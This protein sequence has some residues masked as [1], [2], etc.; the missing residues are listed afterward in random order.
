MGTPAHAPT[1]RP[2]PTDLFLAA[3]GFPVG[4]LL[5]AVPPACRRG[6]DTAPPLRP[7]GDDA[8]LDFPEWRPRRPAARLVP[9]LSVLD[10][11]PPGFRFELSA[12]TSGAWSPWVGAASVGDV[13]FA[14]LPASA[15]ALTSEIDEFVA[16]VPADAVRLRARLPAAGAAVLA[17]AP[18]LVALSAWDGTVEASGPRATSAVGLAVPPRSQMDE[19][20]GIRLRICSPTSVAMVLEHYG[21]RVATAALA[22]EMLHAGL[23]RYGVWPAAIRAAGRHGIAGYVLRFPGWAAAAWCL[24]EGLPVI[25]SVRYAAGELSGAAIAETSGHLLVLTGAA[26][27]RILVNDPAAPGTAGVPR[28]YARDELLRAWLDRGG[29]GYVLFRPTT[30]PSARSPRP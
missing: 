15:G 27:D 10:E 25:A 20:A 26:G 24:A 30:S 8:V 19:D 12:C 18:W 4:G 16:G 14:P 6:V 9:T 2:L 22:A 1:E 23:D 21:R 3:S 11:H 5:A 13:R 29:I 7:D 28:G 17:R